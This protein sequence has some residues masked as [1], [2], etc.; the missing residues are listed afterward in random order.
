[1]QSLD[2]DGDPKNLGQ[3]IILLP[4]DLTTCVSVS[5]TPCLMLGNMG[6]LICLL[7]QVYNQ[8]ITSFTYHNLVDVI[9]LKP[10]YKHADG[11]IKFCV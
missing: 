4:V 8:F 11:T 2:R 7:P 1:M 5:K 10:S 9:T 6:T 3:R